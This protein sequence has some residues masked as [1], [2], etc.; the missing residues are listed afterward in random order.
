MT[1]LRAFRPDDWQ[2]VVKYHYPGMGQDDA[3]KLI[4]DFNAPTYQ[5]KFHK[6]KAIDSDRQ[7]VGYVSLIEQAE[8]VVSAGVEV[9]A[10]FRR[11]GYAYA[12]LLQLFALSKL[13]NYHTVSAQVR[14]DNAAS[15]A[16]CEKVG[17]TIVNESVSKRG[18]PVYNLT[19]SI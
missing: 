14:K 9:Y 11:Q 10:P 1:S 13:H 19:K 12:A 8:G 2:V 18:N 5:G 15:L 3:L 7:V 16:L 4:D 17:F 6:L